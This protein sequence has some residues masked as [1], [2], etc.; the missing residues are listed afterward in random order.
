MDKAENIVNEQR[1]GEHLDY[2]DKAWFWDKCFEIL[3]FVAGVS[4]IFLIISIFFFITKE[5][6]GFLFEV[7]ELLELEFVGVVVEVVL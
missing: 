6:F 4:A 7:D 1:L 5:G 3:M 2:R